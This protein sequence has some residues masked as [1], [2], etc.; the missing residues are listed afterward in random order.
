MTLK[1]LLTIVFLLFFAAL[2]AQDTLQLHS[3][4]VQRQPNGESGYTLDGFQMFTNA[5]QKLLNPAN[6]GPGGTYEKSIEITDGYALSNDLVGI[7]E[8]ENIDLFYFGSFNIPD[9]EDNPFTEEEIDSLYAWSRQGGKLIIGGSSSSP[10]IGIDFRVL[11]E[12]WGYG[13]ELV[14]DPTPSQQNIPAE[15]T[16]DLGLHSGPFGT[17]LSAEQGGLGQ[18]YLNEIPPGALVLSEDANGEPTII[19]DCITLDLILA[20]GDTHNTLGGVT[21]G[22][23]I[24]S[25]NDKFWANT[26]AFMDNL[27]DPP[28]ISNM[29]GTLTTGAGAF[30]SYQWYRDGEVILLATESEYTPTEPGV[31]HVVAGLEIGCQTPSNEI[32]W[33]PTPSAA[34]TLLAEDFD[35]GIPADWITDTVPVGNGQP[36]EQWFWTGQAPLG[37]DINPLNSTTSANG[38]A[39]FNSYAACNLGIGQDTWLIS[40]MIDATGE[41][42]VYLSFENFFVQFAERPQIRVGTDLND[43]EN[44]AAYSVYPNL[45]EFQESRSNAETMFFTLTEV[46]AGETFYIAFQYLSSLETLDDEIQ[47]A[48][49]G[50]GYAWQV[51]DVIV[52]TTDPRPEYDMAITERFAIA[53]NYST[54]LSSAEPMAFMADIKNKG[55]KTMPACKLALTI[56]RLGQKVHTDTLFFGSI[57]PDSVVRN[58]FFPLQ[59]TPTE[60]GLYIS[61]YELITGEEESESAVTADNTQEFR[62]SIT[63]DRFT[64]GGSPQIAASAIEKSYEIGNIYYVVNGD[65]LTVESIRFGASLRDAPD[66]S[67]QVVSTFL[68][69]WVGD[70]D[71]NL[72][73]TANELTEVGSNSYTF[74]GNEGDIFLTLPIEADGE[75]VPLK[76]STYYIATVQFIGGEMDPTLVVPVDIRRDYFSTFLVTDSLLDKPR[77]ACA[78][79]QGDEEVAVETKQFNLQRFDWHVMPI[80]QLRLDGE[81][82]NTREPLLEEGHFQVYPNPSDGQFEA[83]IKLEQV[84]RQ[85]ELRLLDLNGKLLYVHREQNVK[86]LQIPLNVPQLP[87]GTY[88]LQMRTDQGTRTERVVIQK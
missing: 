69:E 82:T 26:I 53:P 42:E 63:G 45:R 19:L 57:K 44:W 61:R 15:G 41:T 71:D 10:S 83:A 14:F 3:I 81:V 22:G 74:S 56:Y 78:L 87:S 21:N 39:I 7:N 23:D 43:I 49:M 4:S 55:S 77:Y 73:A 6:F 18:G 28:R 85:V 13:V 58:Q 17:V 24:T 2:I 38:W 70:L 9:F 59:Y 75:P 50:C 29:G 54:P 31:Y 5:R 68:Y 72:M 86:D 20:D 84:S 60:E 65:G 64:K 8:V 32:N 40:P 1:P 11:E 37:L 51:D 88:L 33:M 66:I 76:D 67:G 47:E 79:A 27:P 12:R 48:A 35:G 30:E 34:D 25:E 46:A 16:Q 52:T 62:F 80:I 36:S